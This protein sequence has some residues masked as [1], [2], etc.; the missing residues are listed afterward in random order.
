MKIASPIPNITPVNKGNLLKPLSQNDLGFTLIEMMVAL[1]ISG[2]L[3]LSL[4]NLYIFQ[5]ETHTVQEQISDMQ[6]NARIAMDMISRDVRMAGFNPSGATFVGL[7]C[8]TSQIQIKADLN[9]NGNTTDLNEDITYS[10][11]T[12]NAL[13]P[14]IKRKNSTSGTAQDFAENISSFSVTPVLQSGTTVGASISITARTRKK[15]RGFTGDGYHRITITSDMTAR[16][17]R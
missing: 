10:L 6:Q 1:V 15:D 5:S 13:N 9:G 11:D 3:A 7:A 12:S 14:K 2:I 4:Y 16:N 17:I 8:S